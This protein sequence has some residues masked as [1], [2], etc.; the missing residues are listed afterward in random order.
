[1]TVARAQTDAEQFRCLVLLQ[2]ETFEGEAVLFG[3]HFPSL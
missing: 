1:M 3:V 2:A